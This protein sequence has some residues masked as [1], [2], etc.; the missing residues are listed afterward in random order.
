VN[1]APVEL[2]RAQARRIA[3]RAQALDA[4]RP[5][6]VV[7]TVRRLAVVQVYPYADV[8]PSAD[9]VLWSR[10]GSRYEPED[11]QQA[12][13]VDRSLFEL[14]SMI[15]PMADLS[16]FLAQ[17]ALPPAYEKTREWLELNDEFRRDLLQEL[18][19]RGAVVARDLP[20]TARFPWPSSGWTNNRNVT[21]MLEILMSQGEVAVSGH[22]SSGQRTWD[23]A[24]RIYPE[25]V[26]AVPFEEAFAIRND[27]RLRAL[28]IAPAKGAKQ[29]YEPVD[30]GPAGIPATVEG[31][32]VKWRV[33]PDALP[34]LDDD[35][36]EGR[37]A[38][39][40]PF[41]R[42]VYD[43]VRTQGIFEFDYTL[44]MFKPKAKRRWGYFALPILHGDRL[45]GKLDATAD[46]A[47]ALL[48]VNVV[49]EDEPFTAG[50]RDDVDAEIAALARWLGLGVERTAG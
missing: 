20:D 4:E 2:S 47:N 30:V 39:L 8:A 33:H 22:D 45:I 48:R 38:L 3:V 19:D 44:E 37:T 12:L 46:R 6:S 14:D 10:I 40:S 32:S 21:K 50:L 17:L 43:R 34:L 31:S 7:E 18:E 26:E 13:E 41:D 27:R 1:T 16:L 35:E 36:F 23:L 11:L 25:G 29:P 24:E 15:R 9:L 28:G 49:H 42:L 5:V